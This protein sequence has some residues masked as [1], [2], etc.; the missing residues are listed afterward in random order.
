M[1]ALYLIERDH[2][3]AG[4]EGSFYREWTRA[5]VVGLCSLEFRNKDGS[6]DVFRV[7]EAREDDG[8]FQNITEE[9]MR[10]AEAMRA[11]YH[12]EAAE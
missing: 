9:I 5:D 3:R 12:Q 7:Y 8:T 2:G 4:Y 1:D 11:D 6:S 10:E